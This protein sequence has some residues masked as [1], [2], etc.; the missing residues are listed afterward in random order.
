MNWIYW[1]DLQMPKDSGVMHRL[2]TKV[3]QTGCR[4]LMKFK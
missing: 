3:E 1:T 4:I 2:T